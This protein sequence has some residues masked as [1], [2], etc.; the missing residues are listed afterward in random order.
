MNITDASQ[1]H[2]CGL[3]T[4]S[5]GFPFLIQRVVVKTEAAGFP[6]TLAPVHHTIHCH[7]PQKTVCK[8]V[9]DYHLHSAFIVHPFG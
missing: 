5:S 9:T 8:I 4:G 2:S 1:N 7:I 6:E 3:G